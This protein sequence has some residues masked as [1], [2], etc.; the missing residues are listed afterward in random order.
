MI[1]KILSA[2]DGSSHAEAALAFAADLAQRYRAPLLVLHAFPRVSDMLGTPQYDELLATRS[3]LGEQ[4]LETAR[5]RLPDTIEVETQLIEG[6]PAQA[7]LRVAA[8]DDCDLIVVGSRGRGQF[9]ELILG[10]VSSMVAHQA[11]CPVLIVHERCER[12]P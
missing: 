1:H 9:T 5:M 11:M 3:L 4:L 12:K 10:S 7:I 8:E 2:F 6:P